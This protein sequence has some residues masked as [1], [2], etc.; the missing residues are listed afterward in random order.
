[1][2]L[3]D[4]DQKNT[5]ANDSA[6]EV[7]RVKAST[8]LEIKKITIQVNKLEGTKEKLIAICRTAKENNDSAVYNFAAKALK[9]TINLIARAQMFIPQA[10]MILSAYEQQQDEALTSAIKSMSKRV[11]NA[12][13]DAA[14]LA[15]TSQYNDV[16]QLV[17]DHLR[18]QEAAF[19]G[20]DLGSSQ[21]DVDP[22]VEAL[23]N[24][25]TA[26]ANNISVDSVP[27]EKKL[28]DN[29]LTELK[30]LAGLN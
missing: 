22:E 15:K 5:E 21:F 11:K 30:K 7:V 10:E 26:P 19:A 17:E 18:M 24:A 14:E 6:S 16:N 23:I 20:M 27:E 3:F 9:A 12:V 28:S 2:G 1:M 4:R 25:S 8:K 29:D 13:S